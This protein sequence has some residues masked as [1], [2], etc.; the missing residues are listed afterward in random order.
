ML[1]VIYDGNLIREGNK[2]LEASSSVTFIKTKE[3]NII[4]DTSSKDKRDI[5]IEGLAKLGLSPEDIDIVINTHSHW[6]HVENN[7]LF[8]NARIID[9]ENYKSFEDREIEIIKTPGHTE[10][11][12]SVIYMDYIIVGDAS[13]LK[14]NILNDI[15]P[16]LNI[17]EKLA[18]KTLKKIKS[19]GKNI[20]TGHEGIYFIK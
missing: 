17:D 2:I 9:Y 8:K 19:M 15:E 11:S 20:I 13:P 3:H 18:L 16:K 14:D 12:I 1:K 5:I 6:D 7:D 4:V 10:D